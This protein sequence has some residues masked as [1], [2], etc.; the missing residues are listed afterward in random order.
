MCGA[1]KVSPA[2]P[3]SLFS[4]SNTL[5]IYPPSPLEGPVIVSGLNIEGFGNGYSKQGGDTA[6]RL[7]FFEYGRQQPSGVWD[8]YQGVTP[9]ARVSAAFQGRFPLSKPP[10]LPGWVSGAVNFLATTPAEQLE[11]WLRGRLGRLRLLAEQ[12]R[13]RRGEAVAEWRASRPAAV[14]S[15]SPRFNPGL[16]SV[17]SREAGV[18]CDEVLRLFQNGFPA[19]GV[20]DA[21]GAFAAVGAPEPLAL[22][23]LLESSGCSWREAASAKYP[24]AE[25]ARRD[26]WEQCLSE[27]RKGWLEAPVPLGSFCKKGTVPVMRFPVAQ[28]GKVRYCDDMRRSR[29]NEC[30]ASRTPVNLPT[31]DTLAEIATLIGGGDASG[32]AFWKAGHADA[33]KQLPL[34]PRRAG[35]CV[36]VAESPGGERFCFRPRT[37]LFGSSLAVLGYNLVS[38]FLSCVFAIWFKLPCI[39]FFDDFSG[40]APKSLGRLPLECFEAFNEALGFRVKREKSLRGN[41]VP[42]L[43]VRLESGPRVRLSLPCEKREKYSRQIAD[44]LREGKCSPADAD[45]LFGRLQWCESLLF[46]RAHRAYLVPVYRQ[47]YARG[48]D[49]SARLRMAL[50]WFLEFLSAPRV[51]FYA[52]PSSSVDFVVFSDAS[53]A[54]LGACV[55]DQAGV[56]QDFGSLVPAGYT[57]SLPPGAN[58][59]FILE[60]WAAVLGILALSFRLNAE[61]RERA[62]VFLFVDNNASLASLVRAS[63]NCEVAQCAIRDFWRACSASGVTPWLERV[64]S[65][66]NWADGPSR[67]PT[68]AGALLPFPAP[69][70][71]G[72]CL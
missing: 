1:D 60:I 13:A 25:G 36:I 6:K 55:V 37:L 32:V 50:S 71:G 43:G 47:K 65:R 33:Y 30:A 68:G 22:S 8:T 41:A 31:V 72:F 54:G 70:P 3:S 34:D 62:N 64:E 20:F 44:R 23:S 17:L 48:S 35:F 9:A 67:D 45:S 18:S 46:G 56:R 4:F 39:S 14:E 40:A 16:L 59:I 66:F 2:Q 15:V 58:A 28:E 27:A 51:R 38:R 29:T 26:L 21:P 69:P 57:S 7:E 49:V 11:G 63:S 12:V 19:V 10:G 52:Q 5:P 24:L 42:F 53:L 61:G